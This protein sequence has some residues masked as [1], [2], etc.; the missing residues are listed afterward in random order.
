MSLTPRLPSSHL[1][2]LLLHTR[3]STLG[4]KALKVFKGMHGLFQGFVTATHS[5]RSFLKL[6]LL[7]NTLSERT[8]RPVGQGPSWNKK[9]LSRVTTRSR[10]TASYSELLLE[11]SPSRASLDRS[12]P[13]NR[14]KSWKRRHFSGYKVGVS[15]GAVL[16]ALVLLLNIAFTIVAVVRYKIPAGMPLLYQGS[17]E[18]VNLISLW[19]HL[20]INL[21]SSALLSV[22]NYC[23]QILSAPTR[24][25]VDDAQTKR[26][27]LEIGLQS[28]RNLTKISPQRSPKGL[29]LVDFGTELGPPPY[30]VQLCRFWN[31]ECLRVPC[32]GR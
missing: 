26:D 29:S 17:C 11:E 19:L 14:Y 15:G 32:A 10:K 13:S 16:V 18:R 31:L 7:S 2:V 6:A 4:H 21:L 5:T 20:L 9:D 24:A 1:T 30:V 22:S 8:E 28:A 25:E 12:T 3:K 23:M 27:W